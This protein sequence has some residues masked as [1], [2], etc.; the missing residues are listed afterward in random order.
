MTTSTST[1]GTVA[2]LAGPSAVADRRLRS[3]VA[4]INRA[5]WEV[6][7]L[8]ADPDGTVVADRLPD[9]TVLRPVPVPRGPGSTV[10]RYRRSPLRRPLAYPADVR[11]TARTQRVRARRADLEARRSRLELAEDGI[12]TAA[13]RTWWSIADTVARTRAGWVDLR[14][15]HSIAAREHGDRDDRVDSVVTR[16]WTMLRRQHAWRS[17]DP[18]LWDFEL[19][20]GEL[21]DQLRPTVI[22]VAD[23]ALLGVGARARLRALA[24]GYHTGLL[25]DADRDLPGSGPEPGHHRTW[26]A[27]CCQEAEYAPDADAVMTGSEELAETLRQRHRLPVR[28]TVVLDAPDMSAPD[29]AA[30]ASDLRRRCGIDEHGFVLVSATPL[31]DMD[32]DTVV[33]G[34]GQLRDV[35]LV[36]CDPDPA[37][38]RPERLRRLALDHS[39]VDR[40]HVL[41]IPATRE[42]LATADA[43]VLAHRPSAV[44]QHRLPAAFFD[45]AHARVPVIVGDLRAMARVTRHTGH[46]EVYWSGNPNDF[47]RAARLVLTEPGTYR[48]AYLRHGLLDEWTWQHQTPI[49]EALYAGL[50]RRAGDRPALATGH[51]RGGRVYRPRR[52]SEIA[53]LPPVPEPTVPVT[54]H[55]VSVAGGSGE[56]KRW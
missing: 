14:E 10:G 52:H 50:L 16:C 24:D 42:L 15:R 56:P 7:V 39:V 25:W 13:A 37:G 35:H 34:V 26:T 31:A 51:A 36:V 38:G 21:L 53:G 3:I 22:H 5:G 45:H 33:A 48:D 54:E 2:V 9:G 43:A 6:T 28:P 49:V 41:P 46:G 1:V 40:C 47:A 20:F 44:A 55:P 32:L 23:S 19:G 29:E 12:R 30:P 8:V 27:R 18:S 17:L 11:T 4:T